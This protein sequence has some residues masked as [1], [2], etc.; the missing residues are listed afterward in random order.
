MDGSLSV[1]SMKHDDDKY[2]ESMTSEMKL[3]LTPTKEGAMCNKRLAFD[4]TSDISSRSQSR[5]IDEGINAGNTSWVPDYLELKQPPVLIR[6]TNIIPEQMTIYVR[7]MQKTK[8]YNHVHSTYH[9]TH[10]L[11]VKIIRIDEVEWW[12]I[13]YNCDYF[14]CH[15]CPYRHVY[16]LIESKPNSCDFNPES[17]I[18]YAKYYA[19]QE[20]EEYTKH[21]DKLRNIVLCHRGV[22]VPKDALFNLKNIIE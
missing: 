21:V 22:L 18:S 3:D 17:F 6:A 4:S 10:T 8:K 7:H 2:V 13:V 15:K 20:M 1:S 9:K 5:K 11:S 12:C 19:K 14:V 16:C